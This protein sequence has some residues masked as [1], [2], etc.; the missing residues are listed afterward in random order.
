MPNSMT[1]LFRMALIVIIIFTSLGC[2]DK[3]EIK[4]VSWT[5]TSHTIADTIVFSNDTQYVN[6]Q[7]YLGH[8]VIISDTGCRLITRKQYDAPRQFY[9]LI[10]N[11]SIK[12]IIFKLAFDR[13]IITFNEPELTE[14]YDGKL[15]CG[16]NY[17]LSVDKPKFHTDINYLPPHA[18][19]KLIRLHN[20][21]NSILA[22]PII[23]N[24]IQVDT[25]KLDSLIF[26]KVKGINPN[27]PLRST[28]KFQ[29]PPYDIAN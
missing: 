6:D 13:E 8:Q 14:E 5:G 10:I 22:K 15:Y 11:D 23:V 20:I 1:R 18:N 19:D 9:S 25:L 28:V 24:A 7:L 3:L 17:I 29:S 27:P 4:T 21:F 2:K 26:E 16:F 12:E